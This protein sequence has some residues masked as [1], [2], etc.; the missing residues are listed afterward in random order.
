M[1]MDISP[2]LTRSSA[3]FGFMELTVN[4]LPQWFGMLPPVLIYTRLNGLM[5]SLLRIG[6]CCQPVLT[7]E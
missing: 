1:R 5:S 4:L 2:N 3:N 6:F 7:P